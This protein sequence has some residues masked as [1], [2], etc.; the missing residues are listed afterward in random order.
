MEGVS[1]R[2][3]LLNEM[4]GIQPGQQLFRLRPRAGRELDS[5]LDAEVSHRY[6]TEELEEP[7]GLRRECA[8]RR[9]ERGPYG[10]LRIP[11][12]VQGL[13]RLSSFICVRCWPIDR[14]GSAAKLAAAMRSASGR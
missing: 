11:I 12:H 8:V 7:P 1:A 10:G 3:V 2:F 5:C 14:C 9:F 4:S 13:S 6:Q